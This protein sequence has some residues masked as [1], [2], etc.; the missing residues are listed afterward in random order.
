M[1][2]LLNVLV[3]YGIHNTM[4]TLPGSGNTIEAMTGI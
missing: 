2:K 3:L 1:E 4:L